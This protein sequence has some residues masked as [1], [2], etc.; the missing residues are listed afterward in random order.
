MA[1]LLEL[2]DLEEL[3]AVVKIVAIYT[4]DVVLPDELGQV[5]GASPSS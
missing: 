2:A 3:R 5:H 1:R 4:F